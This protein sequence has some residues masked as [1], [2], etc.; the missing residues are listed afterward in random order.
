MKLHS[1]KF[2]YAHAE[3]NRIDEDYGDYTDTAFAVADGVNFLHQ[4]PY[5]NPSP[6]FSTAKLT[7]N[8]LL[9]EP[10]GTDSLPKTITKASEGIKKLN[11]SLG[12]TESTVDHYHRQFAPC[13]FAAGQIVGD[14]IFLS[15]LNDCEV[16]GFNKEGTVI[17][18]LYFENNAFK[19]HIARLRESGQLICGSIK[20][21]QYVR[22]MVVNNLSIKEDG[23]PINF[24]VLNGD[25]KALNLVEYDNCELEVG[26]VWTFYTDGF[27]PFFEDTDFNGFLVD[28]KL[29]E[30]S[31]RIKNIIPLDK[32]FQKEKT[33]IVVAVD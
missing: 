12:V 7:V 27:T 17:K 28:N 5:P 4:H 18:H 19:N 11:E 23:T 22:G 8:A 21:H 3:G 24:G 30:L 16:R 9:N 33:L 26:Q 13:V 15:H 20:E 14:K 2:H 29:D 1:T 10:Q 32:K 31:S 25:P 6:A